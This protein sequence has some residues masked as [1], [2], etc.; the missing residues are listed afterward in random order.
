MA[1]EHNEV[2]VGENPAEVDMLSRVLARHA[3]KVLDEGVLAI[4]D[5]GVVLGVAVSD[6][7]A[8]GLRGIRLIEHQIVKGGDGSLVGL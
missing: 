4:R 5:H 7:P 8:N 6:V 2:T 1:V 3:L